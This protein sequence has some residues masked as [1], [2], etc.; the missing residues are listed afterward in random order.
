MVYKNSSFIVIV[1][2]SLANNSYALIISLQKFLI[3]FILI[4][5]SLSLITID[6]SLGVSFLPVIFQLLSLIL[7]LNYFEINLQYAPCKEKDSYKELNQ[8]SISHHIPILLYPE[9]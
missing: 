2:C 4:L 9:I 3:I 6:M 5:I 1:V 7:N 8:S